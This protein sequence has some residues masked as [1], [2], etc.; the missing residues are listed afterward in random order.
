MNPLGQTEDMEWGDSLEE[1][2]T[3]ETEGR[4]PPS[5]ESLQLTA[6]LRMCLKKLHEE[7]ASCY[8]Y[9]AYVEGT[10]AFARLFPE[11]VKDCRVWQDLYRM[12]ISFLILAVARFLDHHDG[13]VSVHWLVNALDAQ[14]K[15]VL[16]KNP[17]SSIESVP[18]IVQDYKTKISELSSRAEIAKRRHMYLA[19]N[20][21]K[22]ALGKTTVDGIPYNDLKKCFVL[23]ENLINA[24]HKELG[25]PHLIYDLVYDE[26]L[27]AVSHLGMQAAL[28]FGQRKT[29]PRKYHEDLK[30]ID[31]VFEISQMKFAIE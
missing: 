19:H 22:V 31:K 24:V 9:I 14:T 18:S 21:R 6:D 23:L 8:K 28:S 29:D 15:K 16:W 13:A 10:Q 4:E 30:A 12:N 11:V 5:E 20:D 3:E 25:D 27:V 7:C 2:P 26:T 1:L 17:A